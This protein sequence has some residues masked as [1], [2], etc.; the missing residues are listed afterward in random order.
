MNQGIAVF[1]ASEGDGE[2]LGEI[3][4]ESWKAA[5]ARFFAPDFFAEAVRRRRTHWHERLTKGQ[6]AIML[7]AL[8]GRP[9]AF[10]YFGAS[11]ARPVAQIFSF[12]GHPDGWGSGVA[13]TLMAATLDRLREGGF[14]RVH[15]WTMRDTP[16]SRRFYAKIGFTE[17][18][19]VRGYDFGDGI[20]LDQ[21]EYRI[22]L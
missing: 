8:H 12:F 7:G 22:E 6:D 20:P 18:G 10:S 3:H 4:A 21:V 16:Q 1:Q 13:G 11:P 5:Y 2:V 9:L 19:A 17:S 15:V 14:D